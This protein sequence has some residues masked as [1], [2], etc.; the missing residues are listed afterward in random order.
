MIETSA[1]GGLLSGTLGATALGGGAAD[2]ERVEE[3]V[4]A[5]KAEKKKLQAALR[6]YERDFLA[7]NGRPVK[8]VKDITQVMAS[9]QR[10]K[11]LKQQ[12]RDL[13]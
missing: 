6:D 13:V 10:Y 7:R 2:R 4:A 5:L 8:Y 1:G 11:V 12:L 3:R 9:Y